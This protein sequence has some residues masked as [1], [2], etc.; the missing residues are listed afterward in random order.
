MLLRFADGYA[1][2]EPGDKKYLH[3][4]RKEGAVGLTVKGKFV[5]AGGPFGP[6][7]APYQFLISAVV[8]VRKLSKEYRQQFDIGSGKTSIKGRG[9]MSPLN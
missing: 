4:L 7:G 6:E 1:L 8:E 9:P 5:S 3:L 2:G